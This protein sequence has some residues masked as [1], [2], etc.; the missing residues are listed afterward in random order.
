M[1]FK[2]CLIFHINPA[3]CWNVKSRDGGTISCWDSQAGRLLLC[4]C[5]ACGLPRGICMAT[6]KR[7]CWNRWTF[8]IVQQGSYYDMPWILIWG[9]FYG[10]QSFRPSCCITQCR[11]VQEVPS[12]G[13]GWQF[14]W[15]F[16]A[17]MANGTLWVGVPQHLQGSTCPTM[18]V[19][20]T[21]HSN[22]EKTG[23]GG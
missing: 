22:V 5:P 13:F 15:Q 12:T 3:Y 20:N 8:H 7:R 19:A 2:L 11:G 23:S 1:C 17:I 18:D 4:S 14:G 9:M 21:Q 16:S 6:V 10:T